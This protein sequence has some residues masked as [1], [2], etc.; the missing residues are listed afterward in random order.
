MEDKVRLNQNRWVR[1]TC[2]IYLIVMSI[3]LATG[4]FAQTPF[5]NQSAVRVS[6]T[7]VS[8]VYANSAIDIAT[9]GKIVM[10]WDG[11]IADDADGGIY[12]RVYEP[13]NVGLGIQSATYTKRINSTTIGL[14]ANPDL[15]IMPGVNT[16]AAVWESVQA[17]RT[18]IEMKY[19][20]IGAG[21]TPSGK[22][23]LGETLLGNNTNPAIAVNGA[24][25]AI[26]V[27]QHE[28]SGN[29]YGRLAQLGTGR[30]GDHF[31]INSGV[32]TMENPAVAMDA[33][34]N[35]MVVWDG[36]GQG[37]H[38]DV[39]LRRFN[40]DGSPLGVDISIGA[41]SN[42]DDTHPALAMTH[43]ATA[44]R[45]FVVTFQREYE[46]GLGYVFAMRG[47][48]TLDFG[49]PAYVHQNGAATYQHSP[50]VDM[51]ESGNYTVAWVKDNGNGSDIVSRSF[52]TNGNGEYGDFV[53]EA[54][55][56]YKIY[57]TN[58]GVSPDH[59]HTQAAVWGEENSS[60]D[61]IQTM[62]RKIDLQ[63]DPTNISLSNTSVDE[64]NDVPLAIG[65]FE[66]TD[67]NPLDDHTIAMAEGGVDN[68]SFYIGGANGLTLFT[69]T[70][71]DHSVK[72]TYSIKVNATDGQST[73]LDKSFTIRVNP[74]N[75]N[76]A[77]TGI[78]LSNNSISEN[79][80]IGEV[81]GNLSTLDA[82][83][84]DT[85]T[86]SLVAGTGS[87]DNARF[88]LADN[89]LKANGIFDF[90]TRPSY[91]VRIQTS[92]G[93]GGVFSQSFTINI[94]NQAENVAPTHIGISTN[95]IAENNAIGMVIGLL[96]STD[97]NASDTHTYS[98]V[99]GDGSVNNGDF[100]IVNNELQAAVS[101][102]YE[103]SAV[104]H[105]RIQTNDGNGGIFARS[106]AIYITDVV[107]NQ[108]PTGISITNSIINE[109]NATGDMVGAL[110]SVD[111]NAGDTHS[112]ELV[113]GTG[114]TNNASFTIDGDQLK[115][116]A[117][118]DYETKSSYVVRIETTDNHGGTFARQVNVTIGDEAEVP[119]A[120]EIQLSSTSIEENKN[121]DTF[122][123][124]LSLTNLIGPSFQVNYTLVAGPG[125][126][127]NGLFYESGHQLLSSSTFDFETKSSYSIRVQ[128]DDQGQL[129][130]RVFT[131]NITDGT[132]SSTDL[133]LSGNLID[134]GNSIGDL[135]GTFITIDE[136]QGDS[137]T[138]SLVNGFGDN[139]SFSIV[140]NELR[141]GEVYAVA[142]KS[143]YSIQ[144]Q[145]TSDLEGLIIRNFTINIM[146]NDMSMTE[147]THD[148]RFA[149]FNTQVL[150]AG[151]PSGV[152]LTY[153]L[154]AGLGDDD[155]GLFELNYNNRFK[156]KAATS[157]DFETK[158]SYS[159]R[160]RATDG[161]ATTI[162]KAFVITVID[163]NDFPTAVHLTSYG[164]DENVT[165]GTLVATITA[166]DPDAGD[167]HTFDLFNNGAAP[168]FNIIG[169]KLY[170]AQTLD[171]ESLGLN[172]L[173]VIIEV[174]DQGG[175]GVTN[176]LSAPIEV[177]NVD[178]PI[179]NMALSSSD[180]D[181][182]NDVADV[183]GQLSHDDPDNTY[184]FSLIEGMD[185]FSV[186]AS[187]ELTADVIF[188][189]AVKNQY[190]IRVLATND[191]TNVELEKSF[192]IN[193]N[194]TNISPNDI[195]L[196]S[197]NISENNE[198]GEVVGDLVANDL[199]DAE[200]T[201]V[202]E[203]GGEDNGFF[204]INGNELLLNQVADFEADNAYSIRVTATDPHGATYTK[205]L[206]INVI[207]V[208]E[209]PKN[210]R[211]SSYDFDENN[212]ESLWVASLQADDPEGNN[213]RF[214]LVE[215][216][217]DNDNDLFYVSTSQLRIFDAQDF[218]T[219][220][221]FTIR[222][223]VDD[224][225]VNHITEQ[226]FVLTLNDVGE[227]ASA[228]VL[229]VSE[230]QENN[231]V[232]DLVG[233]L[234]AVDEDFDEVHTFTT[235]STDFTVED[236]QLKAA[237][238]LDFEDDDSY[239]VTIDVLDKD[240]V[241]SRK[242]VVVSVTNEIETIDEADFTLSSNTRNE[243]LATNVASVIGMF[244]T[245]EGYAGAT[246]QYEM[247]SGTG[248]Q[249]NDNFNIF[250][251]DLYPNIVFDY[252]DQSS[253]SIR[254]RAT[255]STGDFV[256]KVFSIE[257]IDLNDDP[258]DVN[259]SESN[260]L[261]DNEVGDVIGL[262]STSDE[263]Q[264]DTFTY[265]M[266]FTVD[267]DKFTIVGD[268]LRAAAVFDFETQN[269]YNLKIRSLDASGRAVIKDMVIN[270]LDKEE[271]SAPTAIIL[272]ANAI[273][274][275]NAVNAVIGTLQSTDANEGDSHTYTLVTNPGNKF[276]INNDELRASVVFDYEDQASYSI[277][278]Q[279][280][281]GNGGTF[282][283]DFTID[284]NDLNE[285]AT[286]TDI[287]LSASSITENNA[288]GD[289][290]G[291]F[292]TDDADAGDSHTY[293]FVTN[294]GNAFSIDDDQLKANVQFD[295]DA[296]NSYTIRVQTNDG[297]G[298]LLEKDFVISII[299]QGDI[300]PPQIVGFSPSDDATGVAL[301]ADLVITFDEPI[302]VANSNG[303]VFVRAVS[304]DADYY[305]GAVNGASAL[306]TIAGN[307]ITFHLSEASLEMEFSTEYYVQFGDNSVQDLSGNL[308][309]D[310][311]NDN[312]HWSF[313]TVN[314]AP[315]AMALSATSIA[316]NSAS[317]AFIGQL[318]NTD[319][320]GDTYTYALL[321]D[322][323]GKFVLDDDDL[324]AN[325]AFDFETASSF[326][327]SVRVTDGA[328][329][330]FDEDFQI[331]VTDVN[332]A[333]TA[334][335]LNTLSTDENNA[336]GAVLSTMSSTDPDANNTHTYKLVGA[337]PD[338]DAFEIDGNQLKAK[339]AFDFETQDSYDI[340][341]ESMDDG[342][343]AVQED[344]TFTINDVFEDLTGPTVVSVSPVT[345]SDDLYFDDVLTIT[346]SEPIQAA[347]AGT[348]GY[349]RVRQVGT[350]SGLSGRPGFMPDQVTIDGNQLIVHLEN[351]NNGS[352]VR[353]GQDYYVLVEN[354]LVRDLSGNYYN[355]AAIT[356][357]DTWYT[358][359][360]IKKEQTIIIEP[361]SA[362]TPTSEDFE[363]EAS[364]DT[365]LGLEYDID[366]P[367]T[368]EGTTVS[369]TGQTGIVTITVS[370]SGNEY[371]APTE[372]TIT[373][374]VVDKL[375]QAISFV[376]FPDKT[377]GDAFFSVS[378]SSNSGLPV[379][380]TST[381]P[382]A[383]E[384]K[385]VTITG[386]GLATI[387]ANQ[388]GN[389]LYAAASE[390]V[391]TF[392]IA[393]A[394]QTISLEFIEDKFTTDNSFIAEAA[395]DSGLPLTFEVSGPA[396]VEENTITLTG[397][398]G[399]VVVTVSQVGNEDYF[400]TTAQESFMVIE[401]VVATANSPSIE[402]VVYPNPASSWMMISGLIGHSAQLTLI[403]I[404]G[405]T[406]LRQEITST[407]RVNVTGIKA[408]LYVLQL[409][410]KANTTTTKIL[411][412]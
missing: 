116:N 196:S 42:Y 134:Q 120:S 362:K 219:K 359:S 265:S 301:D 165:V 29:I 57:S 327:I 296:Q 237:K 320:P 236:N 195:S 302:A 379:S 99:M 310:E 141:A 235:T 217:G 388:P 351:S 209:A 118:F 267:R 308:F 90:E 103:S 7:P 247:A 387:T 172:P 258:T 256:E 316:E 129:T 191:D 73:P 348:F 2:I 263:D 356:N 176:N 311:F 289:V 317:D 48:G 257:I 14:Q 89:V 250:N 39:F 216:D 87:S 96:S 385:K 19:E 130:Q 377:F 328:G 223:S 333:P 11:P 126:T 346:F 372:E 36:P 132:D 156:S 282:E 149:T 168:Y 125:D 212:P 202:L 391:L 303:Y 293:T 279:T 313:T 97:A 321:D 381:G 400:S 121:A 411:I 360:T 208:N 309:L 136:D 225:N 108:A 184:T 79:N 123:G 160:I 100:D 174:T 233:H 86:Y 151:D 107:D 40:S 12:A 72:S 410:Q 254:I 65:M 190:S 17:G 347:D 239:S 27:W 106:I 1:I 307:T 368:L 145:S 159:I 245:A 58:I 25:L 335:A 4:A 167:T 113:A 70:S 349:V 305:G 16:Y 44:D 210:F 43:Q 277:R 281:D 339:I 297:N 393:K 63:Y 66:V 144:V 181:E 383:L 155:N 50:S 361:I 407:Q 357:V 206:T 204:A 338:N 286:P 378:V 60:Q 224:Y 158:A 299:E 77:P 354:N 37:G 374:S 390:Q 6:P 198:I 260:I 243:N 352:G 83:L 222:A 147:T 47:S 157:F 365:G 213:M 55:P 179:S 249:D 332:E 207:N 396:T 81:I 91:S 373:F 138:Y 53:I 175:A 218:E 143:S 104:R 395:V 173:P 358:F 69:S 232:G 271:N 117:V 64:G 230:I 15:A 268:E 369:L 182:H 13:G 193:I 23:G 10:L 227:A 61:A 403:D 350:A 102:D 272:S 251:G 389:D 115:A 340:R 28:Q 284:I 114:D 382:I 380:L 270:V 399:E 88:V 197:Y 71:F 122:V 398:E 67:K 324:K 304:N 386:A 199:D 363:I 275:N 408:G 238:V 406:V 290:I 205:Y 325:A 5:H 137:F 273:N 278:I 171:F 326:D 384:G 412:H 35:F 185:D 345:G 189:E 371:Y 203:P 330:T 150:V 84:A 201:F 214:A 34:G 178:E 228:V 170:T 111:P 24:G 248:D 49:L 269:T 74:I 154:V 376:S 315:T 255:S 329:G 264:G 186:D 95:S 241:F 32:G 92:D 331:T 82:D 366:G 21:G 226:V 242:T 337:S 140:G 80:A 401:P 105:C 259:L 336:I 9:S 101:F 285:N 402:W 370:Q 76:Q 318:S 31:Q 220:N 252:E 153:S 283:E 343:L 409:D 54:S 110:S 367:A 161:G 93:N 404:D 229:D 240:N 375:P 266:N 98:L 59:F 291:L 194:S 314:P 397:E 341:I 166:S 221:S 41:N 62:A 51:D 342:G 288:V 94:I 274:E 18:T 244:G 183:I 128:A 148:E 215:G 30:L 56:S 124:N 261:E 33:S 22:F 334:L 211:L 163:A 364:V 164:I 85:H 234:F 394:A 52:D 322:A 280:D 38:R 127:D 112:Y 323:E 46:V 300:T 344:F 200:H 192:F 133:I 187:G 253:Y 169:D 246:Y 78:T 8:S 177:Y 109:N 276:N 146:A 405:R 142:T 355:D 3:F 75:N 131:I 180:I 68:A 292:D 295:F 26:A 353:G 20:S 312:E 294:P 188:D 392:E 162:E 152:N 306:Y 287:T 231:E 298:G 119:P 135:I 262:L 139:S 319:A 45:K